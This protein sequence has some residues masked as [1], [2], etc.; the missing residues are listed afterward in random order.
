MHRTAL[1]RKLVSKFSMGRLLSR[2]AAS[3]STGSNRRSSHVYPYFTQLRA[4]MYLFRSVRAP[5]LQ[6]AASA[7][8]QHGRCPPGLRRR[9]DVSGFAA[10]VC[11][12]PRCLQ[13]GRL[14]PHQPLGGRRRA[15]NPTRL[16]SRLGSG[17]GR[18]SRGPQGY[19]PQPRRLHWRE[20]Q[21]HPPSGTR[22]FSSRPQRQ[23]QTHTPLQERL[24]LSGV[25]PAHRP[26]RG[27]GRSAALS[28]GQDGAADQSPPRRR[29]APCFSQQKHAGAP[30]LGSLTPAVAH[31]LD[32]LCPVRQLVRLGQIDQLCPSPEMACDLRPQ[33]QSHAQWGTHRPSCFRSQAPAVYTRAR[34]RHGWEHHDL[35]CA[36][37]HRSSQ[38]CSP[39]CPCVV[40]QTAPPGE[41]LGVLSEYGPHSLGSTGLAGL[42]RAVVMRGGQFLPEN[43]IGTGGLSRAILRGSGQIY[44]GGPTRLGLHRTPVHPG[45]RCKGQ[46]LWRHHPTASGRACPRVAD[47]GVADGAGDRKSTRLNSSHGYISYAV[48]CLKKKTITI[49]I[50][51]LPGPESAVG[52][53]T[54]ALLS[55]NATPCC[56]HANAAPLSSTPRRSSRRFIHHSP[57]AS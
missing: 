48:F 1:W 6:A 41:I 37:D 40:F 54:V 46:V 36:A 49:T 4:L 57:G 20:T 34:D 27:H 22:R 26:V 30:N 3:H 2:I 33:V 47:W 39:R 35:L 18:A 44:G 38:R 53:T 31:R 11:R 17:S 29:A 51:F 50:A 10:P 28:A 14:S 25:H 32:G 45:A 55:S 5:T 8:P 7:H 19:L 56:E 16:S 15:H 24:L 52:E 42:R 9:Q 43:P 23:H 21:D 12:R 13:Y